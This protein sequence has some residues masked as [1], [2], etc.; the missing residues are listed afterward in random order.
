MVFSIDILVYILYN[1]IIN[2]LII[3]PIIGIIH[4]F[5]N[6]NIKEIK[7]ITLFYSIVT[8]IYS[9]YIYYIFN[10]NTIYYQFSSNFIYIPVG[11]DGISIYF[12]LLT[13]FLFPICI[14]S[15]W[16]NISSSY[17]IYYSLLLIIEV[18]IIFIFIVTDVFYFYIFF[19]AIIIP[20]YILI[21]YTGSGNVR[22]KASFYF[23]IYTLFG[24]MFMLISIV[25]IY[26]YVGSTNFEIIGINY[27][28]Q[29]IQ[30]FVFMGI[31][32]SIW[33]KTPMVPFHIWLPLAHGSSSLSGSILL[34]GIVLKLSSYTLLRVIV[35]NFSYGITYFIPFIYSIGI[36]TIIYS[37]LVTIRMI[38]T[39]VFIA[40]SSIGH[41]SIVVLST[42][43]NSITGINGSFIYNLGH[44][45]VSPLLFI[46]L[47]GVLYDRL[48]TRVINY[49]S[50]ISNYMPIFSIFYMI[51]T[52]SN[53]A[54][55]LSSN[56]YGE[57]LSLIG[58]SNMNIYIGCICSV[59]VLLSVCYSI[60]IFNKITFGNINYYIVNNIN[61]YIDVTYREYSIIIPLVINIFVF[62]IFSSYWI[63]IINMS[64]GNIVFL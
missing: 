60:W 40:Y 62:G 31:F 15:N 16:Y 21:G 30:I 36:I 63:S 28:P 41:M 9:I 46:L 64:V 32:I 19:E 1:M 53:I 11:I 51:G 45:Y 48:H 12:V 24:S 49:I 8:Y 47:G 7:R 5:I 29:N 58:I 23:F 26:I 20:L 33:V 10:S 54:T 44:G 18:I 13:T 55:P 37:S 43:S 22:I 35:P 25:F 14:V 52:F 42:I 56:W 39:K 2:L 59:T 57:I 3:I 61:S 4:I 50:G 34:A 27:I 38:D 17:S 6:N